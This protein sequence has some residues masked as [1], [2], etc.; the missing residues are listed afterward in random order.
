M[1]NYYSNNMCRSQFCMI[2]SALTTSMI[3]STVFL[4]KTLKQNFEDTLDETQTNTYKTIKKERL[5]I[6]VIST[7]FSLILGFYIYKS[8]DN[9][10]LALSISIITMNMIYK[11]WPK[12]DYI[13]NHIYSSAQGKEWMKLNRNITI[14]GDIG[15]IIGGVIYMI[16]MNMVN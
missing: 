6:F 4:N 8:Q 13:L 9:V 12:S 7:I 5:F 1:N 10:C 3:F 2:A 14:I 16:F 15:L 11:L